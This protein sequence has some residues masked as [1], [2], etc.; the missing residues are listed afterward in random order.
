M[1][2]EKVRDDLET[3]DIVLFSG[4]GL[5]SSIIKLV[6][7]TK[8][9]HV[10][11]VI[12]FAD[13]DLILVWESTSLSKVKDAIDGVCKSGVQTVLLSERIDSYKG[14]ISVRHLHG[15]IPI[16]AI[17][18]LKDLRARLKNK[19][20]EKDLSELAGSAL[21]FGPFDIE[22]EDFSSVFCSELVAEALQTMKVITESLPANE[23]VP[24]DFSEGGAAEKYLMNGYTYGPEIVLKK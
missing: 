20:Y 13:L 11:I 10:G 3:G 12:K 7:C 23:F 21:D 18:N 2:Y 16:G 19:P 17:R 9:S 24:K 15:T 4:K 5:F 6:G 8:W 14:D 1:S 22:N